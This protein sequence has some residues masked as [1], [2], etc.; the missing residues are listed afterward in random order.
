MSVVSNGTRHGHP[1]S[2][3][4]KRLINKIDSKFYQTNF[5]PDDR[6]HKPPEKFVADDTFHEDSE[7]EELEGAAGTIR[8]VVDPVTDKYY[9]LMPGL[10]LGEGT[11][12]IEKSP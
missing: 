4:A 2:D 9:V 6:A 5:N 11:F 10:P 8:I 12:N 7:D 1:T 3:V